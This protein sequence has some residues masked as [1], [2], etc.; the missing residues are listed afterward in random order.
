MHTLGGRIDGREVVF[1][2]E[3]SV[4][5]NLLVLGMDHLQ[6]DRTAAHLAKTADTLPA[7]KTVLLLPVE[8]KEPQG[9]RAG[10]VTDA[11]QQGTPP[12]EL[13]FSELYLTLYYH[14][15]ARS[16][17]AHRHHTRAILVTQRQMKQDILQ[18]MNIQPL[19]PLS[20]AR[21]NTLEDRDRQGVKLV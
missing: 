21:A 14:V 17:S 16:C 1:G 4:W 9:Q 15:V 7:L 5:I 13:D 18:R 3:D 6:R 12:A 2:L 10:T 20:D 8:M 11:D 19:E